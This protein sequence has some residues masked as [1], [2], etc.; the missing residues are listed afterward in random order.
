MASNAKRIEKIFRGKNMKLF[1]IIRIFI[2][3]LVYI[4]VVIIEWIKQLIWK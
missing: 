4:P 1:Y 2:A 3:I